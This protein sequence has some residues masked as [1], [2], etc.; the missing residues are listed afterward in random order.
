[1]QKSTLEEVV[2][3]R[4]TFKTETESIANSSIY[5][6]II[7]DMDGFAQYYERERRKAEE[8]ININP[9]DL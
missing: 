7:Q 8:P 5:K 6:E 2:S 1:M 3:D 4:S 9:N